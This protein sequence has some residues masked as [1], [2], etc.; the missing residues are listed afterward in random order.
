MILKTLLLGVVGLAQAVTSVPTL[1]QQVDFDPAIHDDDPDFQ[2]KVTGAAE[3]AK[4][5][6]LNADEIQLKD[7][8]LPINSCVVDL[9]NYIFNFKGLQL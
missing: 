5:S 7:G 6:V 8:S 1:A 9:D 2:K 3:P 4:A